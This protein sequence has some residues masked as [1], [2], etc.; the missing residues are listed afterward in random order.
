MT[1]TRNARIWHGLTF[2]VAVV[3][4]VL[5]VVLV[6][7][8]GRVLDETGAAPPLADRLIRL[9]SYFTIQS[10][11]LVAVVS[12]V[13]VRRPRHEGSGFA[14]ARLD[15]FVGITVTAVVAFVLLAPLQALQG[16]DA[17]ADTLLHKV[18]PV[19]AVIGWFAFG[20]RPRVRPRTVLLALIWP[21]LWLVYTLIMG[22][23]RGWYPYPFVDVGRFGYG[24]VLLSCGVVALLFLALFVLA[25][26][27]D[28]RLPAAPRAPSAT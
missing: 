26:L 12:G 18:V 9:V 15:A 25:A 19:L 8:G 4:L 28:R 21:V 23:L 5:Q 10:N 2:V 14:V 22:E 17:V 24:Q 3:A 6:V 27:L 16:W 1:S 11:I 20:P 7:Q 13:L